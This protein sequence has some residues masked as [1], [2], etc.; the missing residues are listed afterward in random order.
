MEMLISEFPSILK[1]KFQTWIRNARNQS[2]QFPDGFTWDVYNKYY[3]KK[4][5]SYEMVEAGHSLTKF[6][7]EQHKNRLEEMFRS[8]KSK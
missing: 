7:L 3:T 6:Q 5:I 4:V 1:A 8:L 2:L